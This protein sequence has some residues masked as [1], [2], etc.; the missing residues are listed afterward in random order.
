M[1]DDIKLE[2]RPGQLNEY[3]QKMK[4]ILKKIEMLPVKDIN[5]IP[6]NH[7]NCDIIKKYSQRSRILPEKSRIDI[8]NFSFTLAHQYTDDDDNTDFYLFGDNL[9]KIEKEYKKTLLLNGIPYINI[10]S[11]TSGKICKIK[12]PPGTD[13]A[14]LMTTKIG[15]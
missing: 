3:S 9:P 7:D 12:Y 8:S 6:G 13:S 2:F 4:K 10:I 15:L 14:R 1:I 11:L 5:L